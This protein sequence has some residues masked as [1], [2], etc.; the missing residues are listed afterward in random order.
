MEKY[1]QDD[2]TLKQNLINEEAQL[3]QK[4]S[5]YMSMGE[6]TASDL[7]DMRS[8]EQRLKQVRDRITEIDLG[9]RD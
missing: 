9:K 8:S 2:V 1:S 5:R 7:S 3:M 4:M 6:K